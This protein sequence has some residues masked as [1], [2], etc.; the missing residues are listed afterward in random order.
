M[1]CGKARDVTENSTQREQ[2]GRNLGV[3]RKESES[4]RN[5]DQR[6][7]VLLDLRIIEW[8]REMRR[9][10]VVKSNRM[11]QLTD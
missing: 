7:Q 2:I 6:R 9:L 3:A 11:I 4:F 5:L 8:L 1:L 10:D